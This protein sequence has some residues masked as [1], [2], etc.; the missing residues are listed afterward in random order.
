MKKKKIAVILFGNYLTDGRV[1]RTAETLIEKYEVMVFVTTDDM[2]HYPEVLNGIPIQP[3]PL[4]TKKFT[5]H[6]LMQV[7]K[8]IEYFITTISFVKKY[9][10]DVVFCNDVYTVFFGWFF[11]KN[12]K[13][14][15]YDSHELWKDTMHNYAYNAKLYEILYWIQKRTIGKADAVI[16]VCESIAKIMENDHNIIR[17]TVIMNIANFKNVEENNIIREKL[18]LSSD[19][20]IVL[21]V[22]G[23]SAGR[24]LEKL[25]T[26]C[27]Y[28][29]ENIILVFLGFGSLFK[30]LNQIVNDEQ[31][32]NKVFFLESVH[33]SE[34]ATYINS[35]DAGIIS[36]ENT[37]L[38]HYYALPNKTFQI[39]GL[40]K[41]LLT[42]NFPELKNIINKYNIGDSFN[43]KCPKAIANKVNGVFEKNLKISDLDYNRFMNDYNWKMEQKK[44]LKLVKGILK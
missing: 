12:G 42:S 43:P 19:K 24:G 6:P 1:Q 35:C 30:K 33:Q 3:V 2:E 7:I 39:G 16:T 40:R 15:I 32:N 10:P 27:K 34:V 23:L 17:P 29:A 41:I 28:W 44:L 20:K 11:K 36:Y 21:F 37:C 38:N 4:K 22:G 8:Y 31:L 14:F 13:K 25:V 9:N 26:S 5:N 18:E